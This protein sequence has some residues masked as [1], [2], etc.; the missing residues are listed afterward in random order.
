VITGLDSAQARAEEA[1]KIVNW[2]FRQFAQKEVAA[3]G[4]R[5]AEA[6][7]WMGEQPTVGLAV[8]DDVS[9]L[10]PVVN[11]DG[12]AAE[13]TYTGP[14]E[15]PIVAGQELAELVITLDGLPEHRIPLVAEHDVPLGGFNTRI[16]VAANVLWSKWG[17]AAAEPETES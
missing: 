9:L 12:L 7:V 4:T 8:A 10:V 17:P 3:G 13:V 14:F 1:E 5:I 16:R 6:D 2:A 11:Q 15:A